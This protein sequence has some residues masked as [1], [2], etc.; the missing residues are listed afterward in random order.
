MSFLVIPLELIKSIIQSFCW[1]TYEKMVEY[2][3]WTKSFDEK[4]YYDGIRERGYHI[5][6]FDIIKTFKNE[7]IDLVSEEFKNEIE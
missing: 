3:Q 6:D 2:W 4:G 7:E 5:S 1:L